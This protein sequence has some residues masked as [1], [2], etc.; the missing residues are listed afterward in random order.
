MD[1]ARQHL[2]TQRY[3]DGHNVSLGEMKAH[4]GGGASEGW[5]LDGS[6]WLEGGFSEGWNNE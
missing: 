4:V 5:L 2:F 6:A 1:I 3:S